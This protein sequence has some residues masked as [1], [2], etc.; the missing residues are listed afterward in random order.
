VRHDSD[1]VP[2]DAED[3]A[4]R[5][6]LGMMDDV[7]LFTTGSNQFGT[8]PQ[9]VSGGPIISPA[10]GSDPSTLEARPNHRLSSLRS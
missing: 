10:L 1:S 7:G 8:P 2:E 6:S 3:P 4:F 9:P 5:F